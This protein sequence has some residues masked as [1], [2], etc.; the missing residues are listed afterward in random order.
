[1][2]RL[3]TW[4]WRRRRSC[5]HENDASAGVL[6]ATTKHMDSNLNPF[7]HMVTRYLAMFDTALLC[8]N[9][10]HAD[11][12]VAGIAVLLLARVVSPPEYNHVREG[13]HLKS[14]IMEA[15]QRMMLLQTWRSVE[16]MMSAKANTSVTTSLAQ[17]SSSQELP[18]SMLACDPRNPWA[19]GKTWKGRSWVAVHGLAERTRRAAGS[20]SRPGRSHARTVRS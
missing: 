13:G 12:R 11:A 16:M 5:C 17:H 18:V 14:W 10:P 2:R 4:K 1:M 7:Q 8:Y 15:C 3:R 6:A 19:A 9:T 20:S